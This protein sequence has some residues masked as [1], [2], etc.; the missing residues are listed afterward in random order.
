MSIDTLPNI[1]TYDTLQHR[2]AYHVSKT[3]V[4]L[5]LSTDNNL[6]RNK[7]DIWWRKYSRYLTVFT[8]SGAICKEKRK[9]KINALLSCKGE[10]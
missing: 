9:L 2:L 7:F 5:P 10:I 1:I 6:T 8:N 3:I 4:M